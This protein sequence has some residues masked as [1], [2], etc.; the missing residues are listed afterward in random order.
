VD[1]LRE[2]LIAAEQRLHRRLGL[3][4]HSRL[5]HLTD[6]PVARARVLE[7]GSGPPVLL[8]HGAG[9]VASL[10]APLLAHLRDRRCIAVDLPGCGLTDPFDHRGVDLRGHARAF[11]GGVLAALGLERVPVVASSL[12]ATHALHLAAAEPS[13][14]SHLVLMG[15][16]G[17]ALP[18]SRGTAAM[19]LYS[20]PVLGRLAAAV[21]PPVT[22]R[23]ARRVL[24]GICG[25][26]AVDAVPDEMFEVLAAAMRLSDPTTRTLMPE[27]FVGRTPRPH[28]ALSDDE[29]A[30]VTAPTRF[31]WG[32]ADIFQ[33]PEAAERAATLMPAA[34][35]TVVAGGH[36]PWWDDATGCARIVDHHL[37]A[38]FPDPSAHGRED[39]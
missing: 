11:L 9:M 25:R 32:D 13:R 35:V 18:G 17:V 3:A 14:L 39:G 24:A 26:S 34:T 21:S 33:A 29:L 16:T 19:A 5:L 4:H 8:V 36:H 28:Q 23:L 37:A 31:V 12:G 22:P 1:R 30:R 10:W 27:L 38:P 2:T 15:A 20:R 7:A 6:G